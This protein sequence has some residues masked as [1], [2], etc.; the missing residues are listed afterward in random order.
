MKIDGRL[1]T[2]AQSQ[3]EILNRQFQSAFSKQIPCTP[4]DFKARTG[5]SLTPEGLTCDQITITEAGV[6]KLM[7]N[8]KARKAPGSDGTTPRILKELAELAPTLTLLFQSSIN[9]GSAPL[10]WKNSTRFAYL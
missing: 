4:E 2:D 1:I 5:L 3:A 6:K 8:L 9:S 10:D 7:R